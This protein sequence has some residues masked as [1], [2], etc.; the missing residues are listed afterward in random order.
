MTREE[1][2]EKVRQ[3]SLPKETREV[4]EALAPELAESEDEKIGNIIYCIVRDNKEVKRI[5]ESN[6]ASVDNALSYLE[7]QKDA[8]KAIEAV[9][10]IDKYIDEHVANAHDM[11]DSNSDKKYYRG[12]DDALAKMSGILQDVYSGK[13]QKEQKSAE[14]VEI[15][16]SLSDVVIAELGKYNGENYLKSPWAMDSTG[17]QYPLHF[18]ELGAKWQ[19]EQNLVL[20]SETYNPDDYEVV[21]EGNA[22]ILRRKEPKPAEIDE[23]K[24]IKKHITEDVLSSEVNKRLKECGWYVTDE[25]PVE[26][27]DFNNEFDN[28]VSHLIASV[29]NGEHE[30]NNDFVKYAAQS[31]LGYAKNEL[32]PDEWSKREKLFMKALQTTNAQMGQLVEENYKLKE[33]KFVEWNEDYNE[34]NIRT[35]FAFYTY[36]DDP[37]T[38]YLSN[39]FVEET[40]RNKGFGTKIL[41]AAEKVA[42]TLGVTYIRLK[43]KQ[44]SPANAWYRKNGYGYV[45]FEDGYNWLEK[46]LEYIKPNKQEWSEEDKK[47]LKSI[48]DEYKSM[49][50]EKRDWLKSL[51]ERFSLQPK[52]EWSESDKQN[53]NLTI[54]YL[55]SYIKEHNDTFGADE[56]KSLKYWLKALPERFNLEPKPE[57]NEEDKV[58]L[59]DALWCIKQ[60]AKFA[61]DENDMGTCWS[62]ERWLKS[63]HSS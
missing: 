52:Q 4:F 54:S 2:I 63:L 10:R 33:Q 59:Q 25:K 28:Q 45:A 42:E 30:Y 58:Y 12:W 13:K 43:V 6:G 31:L 20:F 1:A 48:L 51:P 37:C 41:V 50:T 35:R 22:T 38:L 55:D 21:I 23:Y 18:A 36:K 44:N 61:R 15:N 24:I 34:E 14:Q 29:L 9:E 56:C 62:A 46:N 32:K 47:M 57:W 60:A 27:I 49:A 3:W 40:S 19:R 16:K 53:I 8:N 26:C 11:K 17:L 39:V 5:L 7:K